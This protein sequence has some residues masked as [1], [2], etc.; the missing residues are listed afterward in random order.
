[1]GG[2]LKEIQY[3]P[4]MT[5]ADNHTR[6]GIWAVNAHDLCPCAHFPWF[7]GTERLSHLQPFSVHDTVYLMRQQ[8]R[9][10]LKDFLLLMFL[11]DDDIQ[12]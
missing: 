1:M 12:Q 2:D 10:S 7:Y 8:Q 5:R 9:D 4:A 11:M 3:P 6:R